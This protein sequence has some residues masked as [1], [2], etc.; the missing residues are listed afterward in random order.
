MSTARECQSSDISEQNVGVR[1]YLTNEMSLGRR[2][3]AY[4]RDRSAHV[5]NSLGDRLFRRH[6]NFAV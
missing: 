1:P 6:G 2:V 4:Q 5:P 3:E